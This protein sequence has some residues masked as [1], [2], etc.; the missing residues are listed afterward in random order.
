MKNILNTEDRD[1]ILQRINRL[2]GDSQRQWGKMDAGQMICHV[3]DQIIMATGK[4][5][6]PFIGHVLST[7][8]IKWL[9]LAGLPTPKGKVETVKELKQGAGG[10]LPT[11]VETD[12]EK[13][14]QQIR[15]FA[16]DYPANKKI[17]HP[18]FGAMSRA[19]WGRLVYLHL[20]HH[21]TQ[22]SV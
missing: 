18:F 12:R 20:D 5:H 15:S 17:V 21:L 22:F 7:T 9:I 11:E 8:V 14:Q 19:Q 3:T 10:T 4:K 1:A 16:T 2:S 13:L 6:S